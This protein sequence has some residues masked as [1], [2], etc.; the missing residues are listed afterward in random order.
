MKKAFYKVAACAWALA[1]TVPV[2]AQNSIPETRRSGSESF[3]VSERNMERS[4][5]VVAGREWKQWVLAPASN[6]PETVIVTWDFSTGLPA[7]WSTPNGIGGTPAS[8]KWVYRGPSTTPNTNTGSQG[9]Y[10]TGTGVIQS[11]TRTNGF[12]IFDSDYLDNNGVAGNFGGGA[13]ASPHTAYLVSE[14][15][16]LGDF[17]TVDFQFN[18]YYRKFAG[19]GGNTALSGTYVD[20]SIDGG[21]TWPYTFTYNSEIGVNGLTPSNDVEVRNISAAVGGQSN[22]RFRFRFDGDYYFWMIDDVQLIGVPDYRAEYVAWNGFSPQELVFEPNAGASKLGINTLDQSRE[23]F[24]YA[25][26]LNSGAEALTNVRLDIDFQLNGGA[27]F[28]TRSSAVLDTLFPGD[29]LDL[30]T[31]NTFADPFVPA[32]L[33]A[34]TF[35]FKVVSDSLTLLSDTGVFVVDDSILSLDFANADNYIGTAQIGAANSAIASRFDI[36]NNDRANATS[37]DVFIGPGTVPGSVINVSVHDSST[38][39]TF[40]TPLKSVSHTVTA[41]DVSAGIIRFDLTTTGAP[42]QLPAVSGYYV[43]ARLNPTGSG[44][45]GAIQLLNDQSWEAEGLT[46]LMYYTIASPNWYTGFTGSR[47]LNAPLIR[48]NT[49]PC[50]PLNLAIVQVESPFCAGDDATLRAGFSGGIGLKTIEWSTGETTKFVVVPAGTY[51]VRVTDARGCQAVDTFEVVDPAGT[52]F[53]TSLISV[54]KPSAQT[55]NVSWNPVSLPVGSTLIGYRVAYRLRGTTNFNQLPLT[56]NTSSIVDFTGLGLCNGNYDFTVYVR[57][58]DG[59][60]AKTSA[61][62]C[63]LSRGYNAGSCK[64]EF[65]FE[66]ADVASRVSVY[67]NPSADVFYA[68]FESGSPYV[69][70]DALGRI[71]ISGT[72]TSDETAIDLSGHAAG[73]YLLKIGGSASVERLLRR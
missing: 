15:I 67:P 73:V 20:F 60:G 17:S 8:T 57:Y 21:T 70:T 69:V 13:S 55:F 65:G 54:L 50:T 24:F 30:N 28:A 38:F 26:V 39:P 32:A 42:L 11:P 14:V 18:Q 49:V 52:A 31:L 59:T 12:F 27:T 72:S 2:F 51:W 35:V 66:D 16:D 34:Y 45:V 68:G 36:Q 10:A 22:V 40:A 53:A 61:P 58:N 41:G 23:V 9:A 63:F 6:T 62:A 56:T 19:I 4:A 47:V 44:G 46:K 29:T 71:L 43:I 33:G 3:A 1:A 25:N 7:G 64:S 48:L 37:V 5:E